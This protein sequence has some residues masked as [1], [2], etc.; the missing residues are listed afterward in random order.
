MRRWLLASICTLILGGCAEFWYDV[1]Y[2]ERW[3]VEETGQFEQLTYEVKTLERHNGISGEFIDMTM[4]Y[5]ASNR[6]VSPVCAW[7]SVASIRGQ[8]YSSGNKYRLEPG[9]TSIIAYS[10]SFTPG[11]SVGW[12]GGRLHYRRVAPGEAC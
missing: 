7:F 10:R 1:A 9:A 4:Y 8:S 2:S 6:G 5:Y 3:Y 12:L 11:G